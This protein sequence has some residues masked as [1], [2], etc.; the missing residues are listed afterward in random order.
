M[1]VFAS[2]KKSTLTKER[3][4]FLTRLLKK[5]FF[6]FLLMKK[7]RFIDY[8]MHCFIARKM[9]KLLQKYNFEILLKLHLAK[10]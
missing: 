9:I 3:K 1:I 4:I 6:Y 2:F 7:K 8:A 10:I 5:H